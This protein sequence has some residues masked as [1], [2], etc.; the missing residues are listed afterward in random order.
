VVNAVATRT[1]SYDVNDN[2]TAEALQVDGFTLTAAYGYNTSDQ[3]SSVTYPRTNHQVGLK[4]DALGRPFY[5]TP[6]VTGVT[7]W[8]NGQ[9]NKITFANGNSTTYSQDGRQRPGGVRGQLDAQNIRYVDS[10]YG[11]DGASNVVS[12]TDTVDGQF[13]RSLAHDAINRLVTANGPWGAGAIFYNGRGDILRQTFGAFDLTYAYDPTTRRLSSTGGSRVVGYGYDV[14]GNVASAGVVAYAY[15]Q[16]SNLLCVACSSSAQIDYRYDGTNTRV[17]VDKGGVRTYEFYDVRGNLLIDWTPSAFNAVNEYIYIGGKRV[18]QRFSDDR[19][20]TGI[21]VSASPNPAVETQNVTLTATFNLGTPA[22]GIVEF[23]DGTNVLGTATVSGTAASLV[24]SFPD[25]RTR[26]IVAEY[27]GNNTTGV[28]LSAPISLPVSVLPAQP[29]TTTGSATPSPANTMSCVRVVATV[30]GRTPTGTV[31]LSYP[32]PK[33]TAT[34]AT[35]LVNGTASFP[36]RRLAAGSHSLTVSYGGDARNLASSTT[37][38]ITVTQAPPPPPDQVGINP[39]CDWRGPIIS[40]ISPNAINA[41]RVGA[42]AISATATMQVTDGVAPLAYSWSLISGSGI[43]ATGGQTGTFSATMPA[44]GAYS[45]TFRASV[46]DGNGA[47]AT[48]DLPVTFTAT[49]ATP[50]HCDDLA[51]SADRKPG[52]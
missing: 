11:Y 10:T 26:R 5:A 28:A 40:G 34:A 21:T 39:P 35:T 8:P 43:S 52:R 41:S 45:A 16:A 25:T 48:L 23:R 29:S 30:N 17:S 12:I 14:Y 38:P 9:V 37:I 50:P 33:G 3:L 22:G 4:P 49:A 42:G 18:A 47:T 2:L 20:T 27:L 13:S 32:A 19:A 36:S 31:T 1:Y 7:Y 6:Y 24:T 51:Q 15:D 46:V 44:S